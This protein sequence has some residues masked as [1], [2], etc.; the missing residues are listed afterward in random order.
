VADGLSA[1]LRGL[2]GV[3]GGRVPAA[4]RLR[5]NSSAPD[6]SI[7]RASVRPTP[8]LTHVIAAR[9]PA[10]RPV[11]SQ[12]RVA[13]PTCSVLVRLAFAEASFLDSSERLPLRFGPKS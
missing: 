3:R 6:R 11:A 5:L 9:A 4:V 8:A 13:A 12:G 7:R 1:G 10:L 2:G